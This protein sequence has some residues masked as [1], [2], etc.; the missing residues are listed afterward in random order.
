M[1]H[2]EYGIEDVC[3]STLAVVGRGGIKGKL[4]APLTQEEQALLHKSADSLKNVI[5][6]LH[7]G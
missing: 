6:N 1:M 5:S 4:V 3:L 7:I 2:G